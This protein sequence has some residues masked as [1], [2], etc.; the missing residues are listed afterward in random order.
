MKRTI[1]RILSAVAILAACV[2]CESIEPD[3]KKTEEKQEE[4][5]KT[6]EDVLSTDFLSA[7]ETIAAMGAG[8]NLGNTL[9]SNSGDTTN[10][11]IERWSERLTS[12]YE[13]AWGQVPVTRELIHMMRE[14]G[15]RAI[16]VPVTW[17]PHM[18]SDYGFEPGSAVWRPSQYPIGYEVD[19]VWMARVKEVVDYVLAEDMYCIVNVHHD[20]GTSNTH[21][22]IASDENYEANNAR[23][24]GLWTQIAETFKDYDGRLL[25]E[26][27]NEMTDSADSWCF[28][29]YNTPNRYDE[30]V[31]T[32]AYSAINKYAQCFVD[33]VRATGG[34]NKDRNLIVSTYAACS[35]DG[36]WNNH[37]KDPLKEMKLPADEAKDHL[38]FEIHYYPSFSTVP[39]AK[40]RVDALI[41][42]LNENLVSKGAPVIIGEWGAGGNSKISY[43]SYRVNYLSFVKYFVQ[44]TKANG[45]ATFYWMGI[46]DG[47]DRSIPKFTQEDLKDAIISGYAGE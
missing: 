23:F 39:E 43:D 33:A 22:L 25:F 4:E 31:A 24:R 1:L 40:S 29:S 44:Q 14:A 35:G 13:K 37:L 42:S 17:Y 28:A 30:T 15:F 36:T 2:M 9:E 18:T 16:R 26:A 19:K 5:Q 41:S 47:E 7:K 45:M 3:D 10:M 32:S 46:S 34:N 8:W 12:D 21:W 11:W 6:P 38:I 27:Y 20:T